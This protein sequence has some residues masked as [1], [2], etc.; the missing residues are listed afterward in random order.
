MSIEAMA[1][2]L[3]HSKASGSAKLVL[4]G[5]ANHQGDAGAW[6]SINTLARYANIKERQ[7][8]YAVR[9][10]LELGEIIIDK[11]DPVSGKGTNRYWVTVRCPA[12]CDGSTAHRQGVHHSAPGG[13][14]ECTGGVQHSAPEPSLEP[15]EKPILRPRR[16][17]KDFRITKSMRE[18]ADDKIPGY[19]IDT[20][21][22]NF[23]DYWQSKGGNAAKLD[24][25]KT[26][27][28]W[29]RRN[30][31]NETRRSSRKRSNAESNMDLLKRLREREA[32]E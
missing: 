12:D 23:I 2:V 20:E 3:H 9:Q 16:I 4:L 24:W 15:S 21:T 1:A 17:P 29:M 14:V 13:A 8:Q 11:N 25:T 26:W 19:D 6:P 10:L 32:N 28:I 18:W 5:I 31:Q 22:E 30:W 7:T 27:Q